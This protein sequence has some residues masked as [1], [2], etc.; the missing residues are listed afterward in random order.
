MLTL[1]CLINNSL[2]AIYIYN[3]DDGNVSLGLFKNIINVVTRNE[4]NYN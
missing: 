1:I 2:I 4:Y 3:M